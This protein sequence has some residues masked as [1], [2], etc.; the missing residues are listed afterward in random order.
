[1]IISPRSCARCHI[2]L[3]GKQR[4]YCKLCRS[5]YARELRKRKRLKKD[6]EKLEQLAIGLISQGA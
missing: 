6:T 1:M 3:E 5:L 2:P 4:G